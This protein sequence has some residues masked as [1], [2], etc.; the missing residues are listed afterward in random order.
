MASDDYHAAMRPRIVSVLQGETTVAT[1]ATP[2]DDPDTILGWSVV[3]GSTLWY[4]YVRKDF[5][6]SGIA[7]ALIPDCVAQFAFKTPC[8]KRLPAGWAYR[9]DAWWFS[10]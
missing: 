10:T 1:V 6:G 5:R 2:T 7:R 9:P 3:S 4:V 8:L